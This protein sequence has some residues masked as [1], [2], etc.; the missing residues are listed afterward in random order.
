MAP[1]EIT[2]DYY[3][4]LEVSQTAPLDIIKKSYRRLV[5]LRH[6]DKNT[7]KADATTAFQCLATAYETISDPEK[8]KIYDLQW[9]RIKHRQSTEQETRKRHAEA[10]EAERKRAAEERSNRQKEQRASQECL[11]QLEKLRASYDSRIFEL[12]REIRRLTADVKRLQE[13]D[14]EESRKARE[15]NS[16]WAYLTSPIYGGKV[17]ETAE[18]KQQRDHERHQRQASRRIKGSEV[19]QKEARLQSL[20]SA[21]QGVDARIAAER[22]KKIE[23]EARAQRQ[24]KL[25]KEQEAGRQFEE[26]QQR[27]RYAKWQAEAEKK[28]A[29]EARERTQAAKEAREAEAA[30][31][32][33]AR[34]V[35]AAREEARKAREAAAAAARK[36]FS[37]LA[38]QRAPPSNSSSNYKNKKPCRHSAFWPKLEGSH[39]CSHCNTVQRRFAFQCPG[40]NMV[41]CAGCRQ[42]LRNE[43]MRRQTDREPWETRFD[44]DADAPYYYDDPYMPDF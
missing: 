3:A 41:A 38:H 26:R 13:Q 24:E 17:Q 11:Q 5:L 4:I 31:K 12:N 8:R 9:V 10:A 15:R 25:R 2:D 1:C 44:A 7:N 36:R 23:D 42:S 21:L 29:Q 34:K 20:K 19:G 35:Q 14:D 37:K 16:W 33:E 32:E 6:P 30:A 22:K 39:L 40:C 27:E 28:A 18:Q 43:K